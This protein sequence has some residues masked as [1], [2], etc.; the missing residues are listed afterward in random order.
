MLLIIDSFIL[1]LISPVRSNDY[2][3]NDCTSS[4]KA[5]LLN[6]VIV[7]KG[8]KLTHDNT[9]LTTPP[10]GY[11]SVCHSSL[12]IL[13]FLNFWQVLAEKGGSL[14]YDEL[15][16]YTNDAIRPSFLVMYEP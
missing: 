4:L 1:A 3:Q 15:V 16:V 7:G 14:N 8:C 6:K 5:I 11:D 10:S 2:S 13:F 9:S 12:L